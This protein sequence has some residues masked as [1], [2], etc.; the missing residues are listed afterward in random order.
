MT[1][2]VCRGFNINESTMCILSKRSF[3][4]NTCK[5]GLWVDWLMKMLGPGAHRDLTLYFPREQVAQCL[6][7]LLTEI[8][9]KKQS[10]KLRQALRNQRV[11]GFIPLFI[12]LRTRSLLFQGLNIHDTLYHVQLCVFSGKTVVRLSISS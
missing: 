5:T 6:Q 3:N 1:C 12:S 9:K 4:R 7:K 2:A 11:C 10:W 8:A